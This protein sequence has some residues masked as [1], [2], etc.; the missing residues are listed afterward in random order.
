[1]LF[2]FINLGCP[3]KNFFKKKEQENSESE[4]NIL[5]PNSIAKERVTGKD[6]RKKGKYL[7]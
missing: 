1:M 2:S 5:Q 7:K 3:L 6:K 4:I